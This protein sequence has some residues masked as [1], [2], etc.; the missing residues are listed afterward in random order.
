M[1]A[2]PCYRLS[3]ECAWV[4]RGL[5]GLQRKALPLEAPTLRTPRTPLH[6]VPF[7]RPR[8][9]WGSPEPSRACTQPRSGLG[10]ARAERVRRS[11][12]LRRC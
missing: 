9:P 2:G 7:R 5:G 10:R 4:W 3:V 11:C 6:A 8:V 12:N 1:K